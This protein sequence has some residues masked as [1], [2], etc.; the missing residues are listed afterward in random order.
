MKL[1]YHGMILLGLP[2][3]CQ[4]IFAAYVVHNL[5]SLD[6]AAQ[7][8]ADAKEIISTL[9]DVRTANEEVGLLWGGQ[10]FYGKSQVSAELKQLDSIIKSRLQ[11]L[12]LLVAGNAQAVATVDE[13]E[14]SIEQIH[15]SLSPLVEN[16][17]GDDNARL[18]AIIPTR[19]AIACEQ[20]LFT[21]YRPMV[22]DFSPKASAE[23]QAML[24]LIIAAVVINSTVVVVLA[25]MF[26]RVTVSRLDVLMNNIRR[27]SAGD[28]ELQALGG[29]DELSELDNEFRSMAQLR[30]EAEQVQRS[31][32][33]MVSHDLR[34]PLTA[35]STTFY[36]ILEYECE[37]LSAA[38]LKNLSRIRSVVDRS[39][40]LAQS[41]LDLERSTSGQLELNIEA[42]S[43]RTLL[44]AAV[45]T[46]NAQA[47]S[48]GL[49]IETRIDFQTS[50]GQSVDQKSDQESDIACDSN[51]IVQVLINLLSNAIKYAP[52]SSTIN[53]RSIIAPGSMC[54]FEV[55]DRGRGFSEEE[56]EQLFEE[57]SQLAQEDAKLGTGL[58]LY[59]CKL[60]V[61]AH[62][63]RIG[64]KKVE[65]GSLFWFE[66]PQPETLPVREIND[67]Q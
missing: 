48:K 59:I 12:R 8:D 49:T 15:S 24:S 47:D 54:R 66:I 61:S 36:M 25:V 46:V 53:V 3:F 58:G 35:L 39:V 10:G 22:H 38:T 42:C 1:K 11:S 21:L 13:Y 2:F 45:E 64:A 6:N 37:S 26:G 67:E 20:K 55:H 9:Q 34:S 16:Y 31:F 65:D 30:N 50:S 63:G 4:L 23:R 43:V 40:S 7:R 51:R 60:L 29:S 41:V 28:V 5:V 33:A 32:Y 52:E 14:K 17:D 19:T 18:K 62:Q 27:F 57:F 56:Q 44:A